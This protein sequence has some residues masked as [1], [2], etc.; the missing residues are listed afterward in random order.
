MN[1]NRFLLL[2]HM[3]PVAVA[4]LVGWY[5]ITPGSV[6]LAIYLGFLLA[7]GGIPALYVAHRLK[8]GLFLVTREA[9]EEPVGIREFDELA[10]RL[11][12]FQRRERQRWQ[13]AEALLEEL[14]L[15][16]RH[17]PGDPPGRTPGRLLA[18]RLG[19]IARAASTDTGR[20]GRLTEGAS[21]KV[22]E[23]SRQARQQA[24]TVE[25]IVSSVETIS[26]NIDLISRTAESADQM[27]GESRD[28]AVQGVA[29]IRHLAAGIERIEQN[30]AS[31]EQRVRGLGE[32]LAEIGEI[33]ETIG[34]ISSRT[35]ML[36]LNAAIESVRAG[37]EGR[38]FSLV[39]EE[40]RKLAEHTAN[41]SRSISELVESMQIETQE[42]IRSMAEEHAQVI[43]EAQRVHQTGERLERINQTSAGLVE[44]L[45]EISQATL[46][47]LQ[48]TQDVVQG[49]QQ[50]SELADGIR[51]RSDEVRDGIDALSA[52][53]RDLEDRL[54]P[55]FRCDQGPAYAA[56]SEVPFG[57]RNQSGAGTPDE[58]R[59]GLPS[60]VGMELPFGLRD[61]SG[62][63]A[64]DKPRQGP[65][66]SRREP[67]NGPPASETSVPDRFGTREEPLAVNGL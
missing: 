53:T 58:P 17:L 39:A 63:E 24:A 59:Q 2:T 12:D 50:L 31:G 45:Q 1:F 4:G 64:P 8:R 52:A 32:R 49:L 14:P 34:S 66:A 42:T 6:N 5:A 20:I 18:D 22:R 57:L 7:C 27:V 46:E 51:D 9:P 28:H 48:G 33:V 36:A 23:S 29:E 3:L 16:D 15:L 26:S 54:S 19:R 62:A 13:E 30:V 55:L 38:G 47:Q 35:D 60:T 65:A 41:A 56:G 43:S 61:E 11:N 44:R 25:E 67:G 37:E 40:V 21:R 10:E